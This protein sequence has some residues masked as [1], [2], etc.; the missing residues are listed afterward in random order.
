M[1]SKKEP[2]RWRKDL[3][4][5]EGAA[6]DLRRIRKRLDADR[7][8]SGFHLITLASNENDE[9][10]IIRSELVSQKALRE[11]L[12]MIVGVAAGRSEALEMVVKIADECMRDTG[13]PGIRRYLEGL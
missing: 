6:P 9:L 3:Y 5:G 7:T 11:R 4:I 8:V 2:L 10:D 12:P 13:G 1:R